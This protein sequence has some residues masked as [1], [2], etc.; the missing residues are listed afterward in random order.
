MPSFNFFDGTETTSSKKTNSGAQL[1]AWSQKKASEFLATLTDET[2]VADLKVGETASLLATLTA[3]KSTVEIDFDLS[4]TSEV[5]LK[6]MLESRRSDRSKCKKAGITSND[7]LLR[8]VADVIAECAVRQA[9]G[10]PL[11]PTA[12]V[13]S[14]PTTTEEVKAKIRS[15]QSK[16][17]RV[18]KLENFDAAAKTEVESIK[19]E[20]AE[21]QNALPTVR[22]KTVVTAKPEEVLKALMSINVDEVEDAGLKAQILAFRKAQTK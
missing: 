13:G 17:C 16:L 7:A 3:E 1:I 4:N 14:T 10:M 8:L 5:D 6:A 11:I 19:A 12:N 18:R 21:L 9:L 20:I 2:I 15:L 22:T